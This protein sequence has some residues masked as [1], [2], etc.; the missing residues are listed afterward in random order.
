M[1][2]KTINRHSARRFARIASVLLLL[3]LALPTA[4]GESLKFSTVVIDAGHGGADGGSVWSGLLE[5]NFV[6]MWPSA[7]KESWHQKDYGW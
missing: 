3:P 1:I 4:H 6:W 2:K 5:R 7:W